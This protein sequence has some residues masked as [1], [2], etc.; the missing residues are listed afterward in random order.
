MPRDNSHLDEY[1][2]L[3]R[4][5]V[6]GARFTEGTHRAGGVIPWHTHDDPTL[7]FVLRG[8][9]SEYS[10]GH[11]ADCHPSSLKFMPAGERHWNSF[12]ISDVHGFMAEL[13][14]AELGGDGEIG[15]ALQR[16]AQFVAGP[17]VAIAR[18]LYGEFQ[19]NDS[20]APL[21]MEGLLLELVVQLARA[22]DRQRAGDCPGWALQARDIIHAHVTDP[23]SIAAIAELVGVHPATLARGFR[24]AF[25][26]SIGDMQRRLRLERALLDLAD[27][28]QPLAQVAQRAGFYDQS[29][30]TNLFR[31]TYGITPARYR[32]ALV[33]D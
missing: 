4:R 8:R 19:K 6:R 3:G 30:F 32:R 5:T 17:E 15:N 13:E 9:F 10:K 28:A 27:S 20:A 21:A 33:S 18:R 1:R 7:C 2:P 25:G 24:R 31:R 12:H 16:Q 14:V 22:G 29:H 23:L 26:C 11:V